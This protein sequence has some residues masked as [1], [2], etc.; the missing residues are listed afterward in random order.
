M[1][2]FRSF[3]CS[4]DNHNINWTAIAATSKLKLLA[5]LRSKNLQ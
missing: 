1:I 2:R 4:T 5:T 3:Y